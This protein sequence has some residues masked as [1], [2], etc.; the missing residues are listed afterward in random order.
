M[1]EGRPEVK[2][3]SRIAAAGLLVA[4]A[5]RALVGKSFSTSVARWLRGD[6]LEG[7]PANR[8]AEPYAQSAWIRS[9]VHHVAS[10]I[11]GR[12]LKFYRGDS[13]F[14]DAALA[15]W[16]RAP[17]LGPKVAGSREN[18]LSLEQA[19]FD[20][21][22]W[23]R[24]EGE[25]FLLFDESWLIT[26][27]RTAALGAKLPP[28]LIPN[29]SRM[30]LVVTGG[31]LQAYE[32]AAPD[33]R[34]HQFLPEQVVHHRTFNPYDEWR[35]VGCLQAARIAAEGAFLTGA[36]IRNLARN[37]GDQGM[38]VIAKN[39]R[40]DDPQREQILSAI[41]QKRADLNRGI[42]RD[43]LLGGEIEV[44]R[45]KEQ[46]AS[47]ELLGSKAMSHEEVFV[48]FQVPPS[49]SAVKQAYSI[50]KESDKYQLITDTCQPIGKAIASVLGGV[51]SRQAG[52]ALTAELEWD[53]H[54]VMVEVRR[55]GLDAALKLWGVGM[56]M[57]AANDFL[58][59]G[60][61]P[62]PGWDVGYLPFSVAPVEAMQEPAPVPTEDPA[63]AE[64]GQTVDE[65]DSVKVLR[66]LVALRRRQA[67]PKCTSVAKEFEAYACAHGEGHYVG[68]AEK[69][70]SEKELAQW[71]T[72][73]AKRRTT[74]RSFESAFGRVLMK[75][76][77]ETLRNIERLIPKSVAAGVI[78]KAAV[79]D[80]LFDL[81]KFADS[82]LAVMRDRSRDA[83]DTAGKQ[84]F[85][86][87]SKDDP[88]R[89][90]AEEVLEY[91]RA[92]ENKLRDTPTAI[93]EEIK[94]TLEEGIVAGDT[95]D[96]L[97][98]RVR[99]RFNGISA[100]RARRIAMTETAAAYGA[101][102]D[103]AMT[104]AGVQFK[105]WLTSGGSNV[106]A[107][108]ADANGQTVRVDEPFIVDGEA[109]MFPGDDAGSPG[110]VINCHCVSVAVAAPSES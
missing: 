108:H 36:Y 39:G 24:L 101:G 94:A 26:A 92:R 21:A 76:R 8:L 86:E 51:A 40:I 58:E 49:L 44:D 42:A 6:D 35:G 99:Q 87:V 20:L 18:R 55:S 67:A 23:E 109:L 73:I 25:F 19:L 90:P 102:R 68:N 4:H 107:A 32:Y 91:L 79:A 59:L 80:L 46:A 13:E 22:A 2:I 12:A 1:P 64:P 61:K 106:R 69:G 63:L 37:N 98:A 62:F 57:K 3:G 16:W 110:N 9:A 48:A 47:S 29:P 72:L 100:E 11:S 33:G 53:D 60:M 88:F 103:E 83:L 81:T 82:F 77:Q 78:T 17:A 52:V 96:Q 14:T 45:P 38:I 70:R 50:G 65:P 7:G 71:R 43:V 97:S 95:T 74:V 105:Q 84:F 93:H 5:G 28:F 41:R 104:Q 66:A 85:E 34:R 15:D 10:P 75:A 27:G 31:E 54:P 56:P 30:R 89:Y